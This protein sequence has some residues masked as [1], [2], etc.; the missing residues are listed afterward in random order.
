MTDQDIR[1][2][3]LN[4]PGVTAVLE[5]G[6]HARGTRVAAMSDIDL[7]AVIRD[8][9]C[10]T[11]VRKEIDTLNRRTGG[12]ISA[13]ALTEDELRSTVNRMPSF[14]AHLRDEGRVFGPE[15]D[16]VERILSAVHVD[17]ASNAE[18]F[19][20]IRARMALLDD[21]TRLGG[22][23][24][25]AVGRYFALARAA[26][27]LH[28]TVLDE[29]VYDWRE[30]FVRLADLRP[31]LKSALDQMASVRRYYDALDGRADPPLPA[32]RSL[33]VSVRSAA[34]SLT[35]EPPELAGPA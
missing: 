13:T 2:S 1:S 9:S 23:Y 5:F 28:L 6:S 16:Q 11:L 18:E 29:P 25:T 22:H 24:D 15:R 12:L 10:R 14:G 31:D 33:Y 35:A 34:W 26:V 7:F 30:S 4:L 21:E 20:A 17:A 8:R 19:R 3:L 32:T 27:I